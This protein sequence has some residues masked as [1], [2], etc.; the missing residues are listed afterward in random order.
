MNPNIEVLY[1]IAGNHE[2]I[3]IGLMSG[4]SLDG[5]DIAVCKIMGSGSH[6]KLS[7]TNYTTIPYT[8]DFKAAIRQ[9]FSIKATDLEQ[10]TLLHAHVARVHASM[11]LSALESWNISTAAVTQLSSVSGC[12][13]VLLTDWCMKTLTG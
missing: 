4:T 13:D 3:I 8:Q 11:V 12:D 1:R 5:L 7:V 6:T 9:I 2:R 10:V